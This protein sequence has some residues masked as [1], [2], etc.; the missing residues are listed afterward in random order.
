MALNSS[1][2]L[3]I[4]PPFTWRA[5]HLQC[6][7]SAALPFCQII[8][9]VPQLMCSEPADFGP[10][11]ASPRANCML[12]LPA[13]NLSSTVACNTKSARVLHSRLRCCCGDHSHMAGTDRPQL[14]ISIKDSVSGSQELVAGFAEVCSGSPSAVAASQLVRSTEGRQTYR[15][16]S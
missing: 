3:V 8:S 7:D 9:G 14:L 5:I 16:G 6:R 4:I 12:A 15:E 1:L 13:Q 2:V 11:C 10:T